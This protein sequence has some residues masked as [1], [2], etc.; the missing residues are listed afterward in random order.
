MIGDDKFSFLHNLFLTN[1]KNASLFKDIKFKDIKWSKTQLSKIIQVGGFLG[2]L[3]GSLMEV[4]LPPIN[5]AL[6]LS[7][8]SVLVLLGQTAAVSAV[9]GGL[10]KKYQDLK[11]LDLEQQHW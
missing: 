10:H 5:S 4:A 11:P 1:R 8:E 2:R 7:A 6:I 9:D 3:L